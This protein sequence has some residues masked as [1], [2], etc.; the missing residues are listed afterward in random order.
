MSDEE[1][2]EWLDRACYKNALSNKDRLILKQLVE[3]Y[4]A[5]KKLVGEEVQAENVRLR[6]IL[7]QSRREVMNLKNHLDGYLGILT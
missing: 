2:L 6:S 1:L 3:D 7:A 4:I 5:V